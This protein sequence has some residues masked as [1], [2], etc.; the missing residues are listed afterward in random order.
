MTAI[1]FCLPPEVREELE[2]WGETI[3]DVVAN[4]LAE[5]LSFSALEGR[6]LSKRLPIVE[7]ASP[8]EDGC[9]RFLVD[10]S[11]IRDTLANIKKGVAFWQDWPSA[12]SEAVNERVDSLVDEVAEEFNT[13]RSE[14]ER[15]SKARIMAGLQKKTGPY[16]PP[17]KLEGVERESKTATVTLWT[18]S[19]GLN[20]DRLISTLGSGERL[21]EPPESPGGHPSSR[22]CLQAKERVNGYERI[23]QCCRTGKVFR[24][25]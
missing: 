20:R 11:G 7:I 17:V 5:D 9:Q 14:D 3:E 2:G 6:L 24:R 18:L 15:I 1:Q 4:Y 10:M 25:I 23:F 8:S 21:A 22:G 13:L 19:S 16:I 12:I